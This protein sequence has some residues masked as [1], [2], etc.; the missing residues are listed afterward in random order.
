MSRGWEKSGIAIGTE[1]R[2]PASMFIEPSKAPQR[3]ISAT[4]YGE[5]ESG[6][7]VD[8]KFIPS[9][10]TINPN[11]SHYKMFLTWASIWC[12]HIKVYTEDGE[13]IRAYREE[14]C[15]LSDSQRMVEVDE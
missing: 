6:L 14:G 15:P 9:F 3:L 7:I 13:M 10:Q 2:L 12:G 4:I 1:V 11:A 8:C 5:N